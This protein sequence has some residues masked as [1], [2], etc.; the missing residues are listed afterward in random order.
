MKSIISLLIILSCYSFSKS[1]TFTVTNTNDSGSGSLRQ[2]ITDANTSYL[3]DIVAFNI[4][5]SDPNYNYSLGTWS[6]KP[7]TAYPY[8]LTGNTTIDATTQATNQGNTN[9]SGPEIVIDG[10]V[11]TDHAFMLVS[12]GNTIK[13]FQIVNFLYGI[14]I[15]G[16][17]ASQNIISN[18]FIGTNSDG[19]QALSNQYGITLSNGTT[20]NTIK[21]NL[22]SGNISTGIFIT[23]SNNQT[24]TGNK[25]GTSADG[26]SAVANMNGILV[27]KSTGVVIGGNSASLRNLISGNTNA[28]IL[29]N[30]VLSTNNTIKGNY[31]G[32]DISGTLKVENGNGILFANSGGNTI[33]G[34][35]SAERNII[36]G[37]LETGI[38]F[39]GTG[40]KNNTI[41]GN[42]I[43]TDVTGLNYLD[44]HVGIMLK[45]NSDNNLIGGTT[46]NDRNIISGN[47]EIGIYMEASDS[48]VIIGNF[49]GPDVTGTGTFA[50]GDS[51]FQAN[52]VEYNTVSKYNRVGG[53]TAAERN[54]ISGN[55]VYGVVYYGQ[56][57]EN[58]TIGN[59]IGTDVT[60]TVAMPNATGICV[61]GASNH[62]NIEQ[63]VLSGNI[64]YGIFIVTT[65]TYYNTMKGNFVG[66]NFNGT[67]SIPND[68]GLLI[69]GG[70]KYNIIGGNSFSSKN[71]FS[72]NRYI[73]IE[74]ADNTTNSNEIRSNF[75]GTDIT[76]NVAL[77][78]GIG[79]GLTSFPKHN[80]IDNN[81]ISGNKTN[82]VILYESADSNIVSRNF[83]GTNIALD[84]DLG[85]GSAGVAIANGAKYNQVGGENLGNYISYNDSAG[86]ALK[87]NDTKF[88]RIQENFIA[89]NDNLGI[90]IYPWGVT[91]ND[92]G[93]TD[94][95]PNGMMNFPVI[96][97]AVLNLSTMETTITGTLDCLNPQNAIIELLVSDNDNLGYGEGIYGNTISNISTDGNWSYVIS[98]VNYDYYSATATDEFGNTSE[99]SANFQTI[100][101]VKD[102]ISENENF[103]IYP[104]PFS[105]NTTICLNNS[106]QE[107]CKIF[108][109]DITGK[110]I[111]SF[112]SSENKITW[113]GTDENGNELKSGIYFVKI[114]IE[115]GCKNFK[116]IKVN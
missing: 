98:G 82:G 103:T 85:N 2:A 36:S 4:P 58:T 66:T 45:S 99:F 15:Y 41:K 5:T 55:R 49:I 24:I 9:P 37:N 102:V 83:I 108:I 67:D 70:A 71:L 114:L 30:D 104:N 29:V 51:L 86:I 39:N 18:N 72:G 16:S 100:V 106:K 10:T 94:D 27:D 53:T 31:I 68:A 17:S 76:G 97:S 81:V 52:G 112:D 75:I 44:N 56:C 116:I 32:T 93:D 62:N 109:T 110:E 91:Y 26:L 8:L 33:G 38:L 64:S 42:Y 80:I 25:I 96:I 59:Y 3:P 21:D 77:S 6:I 19:T 13:G 54:I 79:I 73:G 35:T 50:I 63:N 69:G 43:G 95:G 107:S 65:G 23:E 60:G 92:A 1:A 84:A 14:Q 88:N 89:N 47:S 11:Y 74:I 105:S 28:G 7:T 115:Q 46:A 90:D 113:N 22:I 87:D 20:A 12:T 78:N 40:T 34:S 101:G 57:S 111:K 48:N 61:D